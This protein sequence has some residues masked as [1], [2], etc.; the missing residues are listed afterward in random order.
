MKI[1]SLK[2]KTRN[3]SAIELFYGKQL[4]LL[5]SKSNDSVI[6]FKIGDS[7]LIFE[8]ADSML[9]YCY[10]FAFNI[11][12][13]QLENAIEWIGNYVNLLPVDNV[14]NQIAN[15]TN[16]NA[17]SIY[18]FDPVGN[19]VE[20]I[21]RFN[22]KNEVSEVF[23]ANSLLSLSE[24]GI[25]VSDINVAIADF[26]ERYELKVFVPS[27]ASDHFVAM[28]ND[29]GLFILSTLNRHWFPTKIPAV[30]YPTEVRFENE[31]GMVYEIM[32]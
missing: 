11:P 9:N 8:Q 10:H 26:K 5:Y 13:N 31:K 3:L 16:W 2:L 24:I 29:R 15:F 6:Q 30:S 32:F 14:G 21:V 22:L 17:R 20:F 12:C 27:T 23:S 7:M 19:I 18:F 1:H 4:G 25:I 28:G